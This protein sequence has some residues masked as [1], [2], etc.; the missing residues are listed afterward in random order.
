MVVGE[1]EERWADVDENLAH[2]VDDQVA[3]EVDCVEV[4][5]GRGGGVE[6]QNVAE[7]EYEG[8]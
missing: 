6:P 1:F 8:A 7:R 3:C 4:V 2:D 5:G